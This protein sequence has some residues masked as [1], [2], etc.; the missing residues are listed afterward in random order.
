MDLIQTLLQTLLSP[1]SILFLSFLPLSV[2][3]ERAPSDCPQKILFVVPVSQCE[4]SL[5]ES[6]LSIRTVQKTLLQCGKGRRLRFKGKEKKKSQRKTEV[7]KGAEK[8]ERKEGIK[9]MLEARLGP[10]GTPSAKCFLLS[11]KLV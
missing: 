6:G 4:L 11:L 7:K 10:C 1:F 9:K 3:D 5:S 2:G 8:S